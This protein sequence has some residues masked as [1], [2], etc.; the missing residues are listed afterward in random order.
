MSI[1]SLT[2]YILNSQ[3]IVIFTGAGISTESGVPDFRSPN[4]VWSKYQPVYFDDFCQS[5]SARKRYWQMKKE[6]YELYKDVKPNQGHQFIVD[7][8]HQNKLLG[9]ITQ[10]VDGLHELAGL[11]KKVMIELHGTDRYIGCLSCNYQAPAKLYFENMSPTPP[12]CPQCNQLLKPAT[13]SFGQSLNT[14]HLKKAQE[15][16]ANCDCFIVMGSSLVVYPAAALPE[17][18]VNNNTPLIIINN[19]PTPL[20]AKASLVINQSIGDIVSN[21]TL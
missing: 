1:T 4:G 13:I 3:K 18:A 2:K 6:T 17:Y 19:Q 5:E 20:D 12:N 9:L 21:I 11:P 7:L 16:S 15:W 10:N 14:S 8:F